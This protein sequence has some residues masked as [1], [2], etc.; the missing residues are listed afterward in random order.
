MKKTINLF[1]EDEFNWIRIAP[2]IFITVIFS[3]VYLLTSLHRLYSAVVVFAIV[4]E[5]W[6]IL[7]SSFLF[8]FKA[9]KEV[10]G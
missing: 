4:S 6:L 8:I 3:V 7:K 9:E 2:S 5:W 10:L 1:I